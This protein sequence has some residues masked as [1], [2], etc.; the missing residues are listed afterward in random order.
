[1]V[2]EVRRRP[3]LET[4]LSGTWSD[5]GQILSPRE[6]T[7]CQQP[8]RKTALMLRHHALQFT[9]V[10]R[11]SILCKPKVS[12]SRSRYAPLETCGIQDSE[13]SRSCPSSHPFL[14]PSSIA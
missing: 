5:S 13:A 10:H 12:G 3:K 9:P 14:S 6:V 4:Q 8:M 11:Q 7:S 2:K 1:M